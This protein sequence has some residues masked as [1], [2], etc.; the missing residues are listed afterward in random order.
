MNQLRQC[1]ICAKRKWNE[2][3]ENMSTQLV[4]GRF[5][6]FIFS[7]FDYH[8]EVC[9][10]CFGKISISSIVNGV[11]NNKRNKSPS[12]EWNSIIIMCC[13]RLIKEVMSQVQWHHHSKWCDYIHWMKKPCEY[14]FVSGG[15][16]SRSKKNPANKVD[17][18]KLTF[19]HSPRFECDTIHL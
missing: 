15:T 2:S 9:Y 7:S 1:R 5:F 18:M 4:G 16:V 13:A 19:S 17:W 12:N 10:S 11:K 8:W 3:T 6:L 14:Q